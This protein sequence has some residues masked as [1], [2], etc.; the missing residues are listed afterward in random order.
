MRKERKRMKR[1]IS[2]GIALMLAAGLA[3]C[4]SSIKSEESDGTSSFE[5]E[6]IISAK[7]AQS[8]IGEDGVLFVDARGADLAAKGT[9]EGAVVTDWQSLSTCQ[10]GNAGD[11]GWGLIPEPEELTRRLQAL[12]IEKDKEIIILG[13]PEDGWGEDGRVL[14]E[15]REAGC[16]DLKIVDG[17][18]TA[19]KDIGV[20]MTDPVEPTPSDMVVES[21]DESH[22][23]MTEEL[24]ADYDDYKIV[25][26]RTEK[27]YDGAVLYDEAQGGHLPGATLISYV[28]L[29]EADGTLKD[30]E[31]I[32]AMFEEQG[33]EKDDKVVTYCTGGIRSAYVQLIL[34][35]CGYEYTYNYGQS[36]WRWAVVGEVEK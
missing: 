11:E 32:T 16:Q 36:F 22:N 9:V 5:G 26:V 15:L 21:L 20:E 29:F 35:M 14:W 13:Q 7:E 25:D 24:Q 18:I 19:M 12:G 33:I 28:D 3:G 30:N 4:G 6:F 34:E 31:T 1:I 8:K 10:E 27:E 2:V 17:G 23:I